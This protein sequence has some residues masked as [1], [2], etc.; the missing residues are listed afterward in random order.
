MHTALRE[1]GVK[2]VPRAHSLVNFITVCRILRSTCGQVGN[3]QEVVDLTVSSELNPSPSEKT[4]SLL[5][6]TRSQEL[7]A[8]VTKTKV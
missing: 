2:S 5:H 1:D 7:G 6:R 3:A 8:A 4:S